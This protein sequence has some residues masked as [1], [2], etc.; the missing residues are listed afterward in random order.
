V[1][2]DFRKIV[3]YQKSNDLAVQIY[4]ISKSR[5]PKEEQYGLTSQMRRAAV[6]VPANIA[7]GSGRRY[8][9]EFLHFLYNA[10]ASLAETECYTYL[11]AR[12]GYLGDA[13]NV[14]NKIILE[15][16]RILE[17]LIRSVEKQ[18][19]EGKIYNQTSS[20]SLAA[21]SSQLKWKGGSGKKGWGM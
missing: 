6:S 5:F 1:G 19:A 15:V 2:R 20:S 4:K 12:L 7:E 16:G 18:I 8:L 17:G 21:R 11:A 10:K 3:A 13:E 14:M 9:K